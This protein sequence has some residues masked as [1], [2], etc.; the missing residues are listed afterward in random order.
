MNRLAW[1]AT[2]LTFALAGCGA[3]ETTEPAEAPSPAP[4]PVTAVDQATRAVAILRTADGSAAG[5][6]TA[7]DT[8]GQVVIALSVQGLPPGQHGV[9]VHTTGRCD[10]PGFDSAGG[11]WN[12]TNQKHGIEDPEGQHAGDMP[13][14]TVAQDG[15]GTLEYRLEGAS[16]DGLF[17]ADGSA[18]VVHAG[19][20]DQRTDPSGDSGARIACGVFERGQLVS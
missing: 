14:L 12:P 1:T 17:D 2:V 20:D 7:T 11:H 3:P 4:A 5:S 15:R 13:N 18:F 8:G 6:A 19:A 10:A 9:H 16:F